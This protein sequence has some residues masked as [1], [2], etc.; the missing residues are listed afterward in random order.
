M[1]LSSG[2]LKL[3]LFLLIMKTVDRY[4]HF[5]LFSKKDSCVSC[6]PS[7]QHCIL[8]FEGLNIIC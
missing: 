8:L 7:Q 4:C 5:I 2:Y 1:Q 6:V 3:L